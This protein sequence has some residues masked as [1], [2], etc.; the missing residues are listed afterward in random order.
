MPQSGSSVL[1]L[2]NYAFSWQVAW[3]TCKVQT[4]D[5]VMWKGQ[6]NERSLKLEDDPSSWRFW[7][8]KGKSTFN[9]RLLIALAFPSLLST[10]AEELSSEMLCIQNK[11][12]HKHHPLKAPLGFLSKEN[13]VFC[14][15]GS[16]ES[17]PLR[18]LITS[19]KVLMLLPK[20]VICICVNLPAENSRMVSYWIKTALGEVYKF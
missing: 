4:H 13:R 3:A 6:G 16:G 18:P 7:Q 15:A 9:V 8:S 11:P 10:L 12:P 5:P 14:W 2:V 17:E 20:E 19:N 1:S